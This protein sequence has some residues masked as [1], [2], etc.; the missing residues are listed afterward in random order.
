M[1]ITAMH[2]KT[3]TPAELDHYYKT[4]A[5]CVKAIVARESFGHNI[6]DCCTGDGAIADALMD[7]GFSVVATE[8]KDRGYGLTGRDFL[9]ED[10]LLAPEMIINP[11]FKLAD[12]FV[13]H[14]IN[15]GVRKLAV[16]QRLAWLEGGKR[17]N[18]LWRVHPPSR[19]W[20]FS[21]RQTLWR[22]DD[23]DAKASGGAIPFAWFVWEK[24]HKGPVLDWIGD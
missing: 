6:W 2:G 22:G 10:T 4:P 18:T 12:E 21:K 13:S 20:V 17:L 1:A 15:L 3:K 24:N 16:F 19:I 5:S 7:S 9:Q 23:P 8:L 14:A 11:P